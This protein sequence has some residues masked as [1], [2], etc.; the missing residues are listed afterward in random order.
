MRGMIRR[1]RREPINGGDDLTLFY[2]ARS[3]ADMPYYA[4]LSAL[5]KRYID[6]NLAFSR[7]PDQPRQYVQD[8]LLQRA[9]RVIELLRDEQCYIYLCGVKGMEHG[10][11]QAFAEICAQYGSDW[12]TIE[13]QLREQRRLHIETY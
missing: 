5:P 6:L 8:L 9:E 10:I 1:R 7:E 13:A 3:P 4:E 12:K 11:M 2:G